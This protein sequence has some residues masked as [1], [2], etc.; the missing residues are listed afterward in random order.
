MGI[1]LT[2]PICKRN[3]VASCPLCAS[4]GARGN[5]VR[6]AAELIHWRSGA[7]SFRL[8]NEDRRRSVRR[9]PDVRVPSSPTI[10]IPNFPIML[11]SLAGLLVTRAP[12]TL[13]GWRFIKD[14]PARVI[15]GELENPDSRCGVQ[16]L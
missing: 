15:E 5:F 14:Q 16:F 8:G 12:L 1:I 10:P 3:G 4:G 11:A 7:A 2:E 6:S 13:D 9:I